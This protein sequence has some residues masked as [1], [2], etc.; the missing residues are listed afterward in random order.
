M[1]MFRPNSMRTQIIASIGLA[2]IVLLSAYASDAQP[3][4]MKASDWLGHVV[5]TRDGKELGTVRD[6]AIDEHSRKVLYLVVS[7]GSFLIENN[8]IAVAPEAL[9]RSSTEAGVLLLDADPNALIK[10]KRFASDSNWPAAADVVR[11]EP[12]SSPAPVAGMAGQPAPVA[13]RPNGTATIESRSKT[14]HLSASERVITDTSPPPA[15]PPVPASPPKPG[16]ATARLPPITPF[17]TYDK[18]GDGV[19]NRS[20]FA[21]LMSPQDSYSKVD[22]NANGVIDRDEFDT[23][24]QSHGNTP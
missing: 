7:V 24:E 16:S 14:A 18:D 4:P 11:A 22:A 1:R 5:T 9:V 19:L 17:D 3:A 23:F 15:P 20:E 10:A 2:A 8:L 12:A 13:P 21:H 6:V